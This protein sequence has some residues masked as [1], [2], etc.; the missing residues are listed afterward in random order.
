MLCK[1]SKDKF[2]Q[3]KH[4]SHTSV[5]SKSQVFGKNIY[6]INFL[7]KLG[8]NM[9][10]AN[11][12]CPIFISFLPFYV[13]FFV[14]LSWNRFLA[15]LSA[16]YACL[17]HC[18]RSQTLWGKI[19]EII[20]SIFLSLRYEIAYRYMSNLSTTVHLNERF[21]YCDLYKLIYTFKMQ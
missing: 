4:G 1:G 16:L 13:L 17:L 12:F 3:Y 18:Y 11:L 8:H 2:G 7:E 9:K 10:A 5:S 21:M 20:N 14:V 19:S 6:R 15:S